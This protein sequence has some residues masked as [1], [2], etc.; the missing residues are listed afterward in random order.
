MST[1]I[2]STLTLGVLAASGLLAQA[3]APKKS[4]PAKP[5]AGNPAAPKPAAAKGSLMDPPSLK[6]T[7]PATYRVRMTTTAGDVVIEVT[8]AWAP[9]GADR[10]YNLVR[11][12][13]YNGAA[14]FR[15]VPN[16]VVQWGLSPNPAVNKAWATANI[17][18]D[19]V[20]ENNIKGYVT[21]AKTGEPNSRSTQVFISLRDNRFLDS[22][23]FAPFG[24][25]VTGMNVVDKINSQYG[26]QP[27]Q[28]MIQQQGNA[29]LNRSFPKLDYIKSARIEEGAPAKQAK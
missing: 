27:D 22:Q 2:R 12:G 26:D 11:A 4:D 17:K 28:G 29:Y 3:P 6:A 9:I 10:F 8:R 1:R 16:F 25:V 15:I 24:E 14:F 7:A 19:P 20:K 18:D 13:F 5:A 23:G 21:F